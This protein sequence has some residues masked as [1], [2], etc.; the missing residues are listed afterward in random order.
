MDCF[1]MENIKKSVIR[2]KMCSCNFVKTPHDSSPNSACMIK[3][4]T[5]RTEQS[6]VWRRYV[7]ENIKTLSPHMKLKIDTGRHTVVSYG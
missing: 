3:Q 5:E 2:E 4:G 6:N 1:Y 7:D